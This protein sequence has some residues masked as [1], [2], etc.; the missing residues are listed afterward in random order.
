MK[1][2][3]KKVV[4]TDCV[5]G[6]CPICHGQL[7][8]VD[9]SP[10][11]VHWVCTS[12]AC[13]GAEGVDYDGEGNKIFDGTHNFVKHIWGHEYALRPI[14]NRTQI[15]KK[16]VQTPSLNECTVCMRV[17]GRVL[18]TVRNH[19]NLHDAR[20]KANEK[21]SEM[22][23]GDLEDIDWDAVYCEDAAGHRVDYF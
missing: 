12:C 1:V 6:I 2:K 20:T 22:D 11:Y 19:T 3:V 14:A 16:D 13:T 17:S 15:S 10:D 5:E 8:Y 18:V 23:F 7:T 21:V 4:F 9:T